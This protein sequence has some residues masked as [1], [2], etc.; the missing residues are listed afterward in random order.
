MENRR[1]M[2]KQGCSEWM[3]RITQICVQNKRGGLD[4]EAYGWWQDLLHTPMKWDDYHGIG[5]LESPYFL[6]LIDTFPPTV[7]HE[8]KEWEIA[9]DEAES[10]IKTCLGLQD[11][12]RKTQRG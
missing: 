3:L 4:E 8:I 5:Q 2:P 9:D 12:P 7:E 6:A 10:I 11:S 1:M